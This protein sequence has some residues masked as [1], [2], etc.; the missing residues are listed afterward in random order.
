MPKQRVVI[1][2]PELTHCELRTFCSNAALTVSGSSA[3]GVETAKMRD[4][5]RMRVDVDVPAI[6]AL[7]S[8]CEK[9]LTLP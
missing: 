9:A 3:Q 7:E 1:R 6:V 8:P 5:M 4:E 2:S